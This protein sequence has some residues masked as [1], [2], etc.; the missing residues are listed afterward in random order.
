MIDRVG[1]GTRQTEWQRTAE[2]V[3]IP[4]GILGCDVAL[5][6]R[7]LHGDRTHV[8]LERIDHCLGVPDAAHLNL[9]KREITESTQQVVHFVR[10]VCLT[11]LHQTLQLAL[12]VDQHLWV[13]EFTQFLRAE[14]IVQQVTIE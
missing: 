13:E 7:D 10:A 14:E 8:G 12:D 2:C 4:R 5:L 11:G 1:E 3:P 9:G 6:A